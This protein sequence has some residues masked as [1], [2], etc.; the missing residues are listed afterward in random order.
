[1]RAVNRRV[2]KLVAK[3]LDD[4]LINSIRSLAAEQDVELDDASVKRL[5]GIIRWEFGGKPSAMHRIE[6]LAWVVVVNLDS[7]APAHSSI[8]VERRYK[9][10]GMQ[11]RGLGIGLTEWARTTRPHEPTWEKADTRELDL[12]ARGMA[13]YRGLPTTEKQTSALRVELRDR[14]ETEPSLK[15]LRDSLMRKAK[16]AR[17]RL[18][19]ELGR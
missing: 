16:N 2:K 8:T 13:A 1:M 7:I 15:V 14:L 3:R 9:K 17:A 12:F 5:K 4:Q 18:C 6:W 19:T 11:L 10:V